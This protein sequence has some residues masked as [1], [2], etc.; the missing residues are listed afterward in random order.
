[1]SL[2]YFGIRVTDLDRSVRF[3]TGTLGL[4]ER[5]RG[6]MSHGGL[7]VS[8]EDPETHQLLE[9]NWYPPD[10]PYATPYSVGEGLD[11]LAF[12]VKDARATIRELLAMGAERAVE[13]WLEE[14][15]YWIGY[16]KDPDGLWLEIESPVD[17]LAPT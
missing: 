7:W 4:R 12:D 14:G 3:Y 5:K 17:P 1:M 9:L 11:H 6:R 13:P 16:V 2:T 15:R 8:L 10:S